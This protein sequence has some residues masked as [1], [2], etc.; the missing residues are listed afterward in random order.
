MTDREIKNSL[1]ALQGVR[2]IGDP[3]DAWKR[4]TR[5]QLLSKI[6]QDLMASPAAGWS[7]AASE[8]VRL[9]FPQAFTRFVFRP[10][11][12]SVGMLGALLG[13]WVTTVSASYNSLP[14][15]RLYA[16]KI[17]AERAQANLVLNPGDR[18]RLRVEFLGRRVEEVAKIAERQVP[19]KASKASVAVEKMK[20]EISTVQEQI[21][22]LKQSKPDQAVEVAKLVDRKAGEFNV[23]LSSSGREAT[24]EVQS[25]VKAAKDLMTD[26]SVQAV[27]VL[28]ENRGDAA[29]QISASALKEKVQEKITAVAAENPAESVA[30][31]EAQKRLA[32]D[33]LAGALSK[34][35]EVTSRAASS[36]PPV[37]PLVETVPTSANSITLPLFGQVT[38]S[39]TSSTTPL[40]DKNVSSTPR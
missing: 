35:G 22:T 31:D 13:G 18:V 9:L 7:F 11:L 40:P 21:K 19:G 5:E 8:W 2:G 25:A 36:T 24:A 14:G 16:V 28:V 1:R 10:A 26:A 32:K 30:L 33:D 17:A 20:E 4:R 23:L 6:M 15:D 37:L 34:V 38:G 39:G 29:V 27:A 3:D 12:V